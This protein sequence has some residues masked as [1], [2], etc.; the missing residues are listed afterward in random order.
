[1]IETTTTK[2]AAPVVEAGGK[3]LVTRAEK[4]DTFHPNVQTKAKKRRNIPFFST[5]Y[6][7]NMH[8]N[9]QKLCKSAVVV[10]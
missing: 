8:K 9:E 7:L 10:Q 6:F 3:L 1:M 4:K 5:A 2:M